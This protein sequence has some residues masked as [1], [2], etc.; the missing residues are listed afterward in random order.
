MWGNRSAPRLLP[1]WIG[2]RVWK[3][4]SRQHSTESLC[5]VD[6]GVFNCGWWGMTQPGRPRAKARESAEVISGNPA[7]I[8]AYD[9]SGLS[10]LPCATGWVVPRH[11]QFLYA[12]VN[13]AKRSVLCGGS[14]ASIPVR[15]S[16]WVVGGAPSGSHIEPQEHPEATMMTESAA[17]TSIQDLSAALTGLAAKVAP[18]IVSVHSHRSRSS[19]FVWRP[20]L[21][22]TAEKPCPRR[23]VRRHAPGRG[24]RRGATCRT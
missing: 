4:P 18:G 15:L 7:H 9:L 8:S 1:R 12:L 16:T 19:G 14:H 3:H 5:A 23:R 21:I 2:G 17:F 6:Q 24:Y 20:G 10:A 13:G 11:P 22:V